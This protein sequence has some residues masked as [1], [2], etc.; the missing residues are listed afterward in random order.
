MSRYSGAFENRQ[1]ETLKPTHVNLVGRQ[2]RCRTDRIVVSE[3]DV[4]EPLIPVILLFVDDHS[5]RLGHSVVYPLNAPV[6][7]RMIGACDKL[8]H[9]QQV[10][11]SL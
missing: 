2:S 4:R 5:Q 1:G 3:L 8:A 9:T 11:Y 7:V 10:V 6:A